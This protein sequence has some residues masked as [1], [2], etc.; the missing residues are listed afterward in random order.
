MD[1]TELKRK[2]ATAHL[3]IPAR[4]SRTVME[5]EAHAERMYTLPT[6]RQVSDGLCSRWSVCRPLGCEHLTICPLVRPRWL[7]PS[8]HPWCGGPCNQCG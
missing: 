6:N 3:I 8:D 4:D 1:K 2:G 5:L 7:R